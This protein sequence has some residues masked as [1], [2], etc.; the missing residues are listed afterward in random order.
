MVQQVAPEVEGKNPDAQELQTLA[1]E[2]VAQLAM[3]QAKQE[4]PAALGRKPEAQAVQTE[5]VAQV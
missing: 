3:V 4:L 2:H 5:L 1:A